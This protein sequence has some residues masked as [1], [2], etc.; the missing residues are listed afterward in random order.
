ME[1]RLLTR[2][3]DRGLFKNSMHDARAK[4]GGTFRE[5][6]SSR[7]SDIQ[8]TFARLFGVYEENSSEPEKLR[9]GFSLHALNEFGQSFPTPDLTE[10]PPHAVFEAGQL[11]SSDFNAA[12]TL[13]HGSLIVLG[14]LQAQAFL[15]YPMVIPTDISKLYRSFRRVGPP[16]KLPYAETLDG[17]P[18]WM[19]AMILDGEA[20][21]AQVRL[22]MMGGFQSDGV[23]SSI[24]FGISRSDQQV[25]EIGLHPERSRVA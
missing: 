10:Y 7:V 5:N 4:R 19:Q 3:A 15:I 17:D 2:E 20:L 1:L 13:R 25:A 11:W 14:L 9:G 21:R 22:A 23:I 6:S 24:R 16:F 18:V 8:L 12:L